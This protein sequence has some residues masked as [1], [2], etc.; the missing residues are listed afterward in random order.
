MDGRECRWSVLPARNALICESSDLD[1]VPNVLPAVWGV[2]SSLSKAPDAGMLLRVSSNCVGSH[3]PASTLS[4]R[5][6]RFI[7]DTIAMAKTISTS[8]DQTRAILQSLDHL[9]TILSTLLTPGLNPDVDS[10]CHAKLGVSK[11]SAS[12]GLAISDSIS[13]FNTRESKEVWCISENVTAT[14]LLGIVVVLKAVALYE[15]VFVLS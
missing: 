5:T 2:P 7:A 11:S 1:E 13:I 3:L 15:G 4:L 10:I 6:E 14:R 12:V 8:R 9:R